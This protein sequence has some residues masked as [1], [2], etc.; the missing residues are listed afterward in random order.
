MLDQIE[1]LYL[2]KG[3]SEYSLEP[4]KRLMAKLGHPERHPRILHAAGTN[5]KG[6][7]LIA[8]EGLLRASGFTTGLYTSPHLVRLNER[9]RIDGQPVTDELLDWSYLELC[10]RVGLDPKNPKAGMAELGE[11]YSFFELT[12]AMGLLLFKRAQVDWLLLETGLGGRLDATNVIEHPKALLL[13]RIGLDHQNVLGETLE[14]I[15]QEKLLIAK[16]TTPFYL[17]RQ[18]PGLKGYLEGWLDERKIPHYS[19]PKDH[20]L[21]GETFC[22]GEHR[23]DLSGRGLIGDYQLQNLANALACYLDLIEEP[24]SDSEIEGVLAGLRWPGRMEM[25]QEGLMVEGAHNEDAFGELADY[26]A[27]HHAK[28][29]VLLGLGLIR[30]KKGLERLRELKNVDLVALD[31]AYPEAR[32][33]REVEE[34]LRALGLAVTARLDLGS[35]VDL[36]MGEYALKVVTG[37]LYLI[38]ELK[39]LLQKRQTHQEER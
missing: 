5:G 2:L 15:A 6:S 35:F 19:E 14:E 9:F 30:H 23:I 33:A 31:F 25:V 1:E 11:E 34:E 10:E 28:E 39:A 3:K 17:A 7:T 4:T 12:F 37:S 21:E 38:G 36:P 32:T 27:R 18:N 22:K 8:L 29:R 26:L 20:R 24:L 16:G 13:T